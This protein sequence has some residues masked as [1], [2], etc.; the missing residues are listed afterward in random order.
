MKRILI[1]GIGGAGMNIA[2]HVKDMLNSK[3]RMIAVN[4]D[5]LCL[6]NSDYTEKL[7]LSSEMK[8]L[9]LYIKDAISSSDGELTEILKNEEILVLIAGLGGI[10]GT[11][12]IYH[13][14][15]LAIS[16]GITVI[17]AVT[18]P[19]VF[20]GDRRH[21]ALDMLSQL[22]ALN[23]LSVLYH[24]NE[25]DIKDSKHESLSNV[26]KQTSIKIAA[27]VRGAINNQI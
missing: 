15:T 3:A 14:A 1:M 5:K 9:N 10:T 27:E 26:F 25:I 16:M 24:D 22:K 6:N 20:E 7:L 13:I 21:I 19:F 12:A 2:P 23:C 18:L 17:V 11:E 4:T 8:N